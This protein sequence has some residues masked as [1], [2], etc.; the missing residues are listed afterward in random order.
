[1]VCVNLIRAEHHQREAAAG[2][3][4]QHVGRPTDIPRS[5]V[6]TAGLAA[7]ESLSMACNAGAARN[8]EETEKHFD[9]CVAEFRH[10]PRR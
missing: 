9:R 6:Q 3:V 10:L 2:S 5:D 1:V 7:L 8:A 4:S